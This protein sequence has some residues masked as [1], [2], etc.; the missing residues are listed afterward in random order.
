MKKNS[1]GHKS[2]EKEFFE[3]VYMEYE[4]WVGIATSNY[5]SEKLTERLFSVVI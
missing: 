1:N 4:S 3:F 2:I 5:E